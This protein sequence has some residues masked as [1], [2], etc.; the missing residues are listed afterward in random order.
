MKVA[1]FFSHNDFCPICKKYLTR[2]AEVDVMVD[3]AKPDDFILAGAVFYNFNGIR[4]TKNVD[5]LSHTKNHRTMMESICKKFPKTFTLNTRFTLRMNKSKL[6]D[7]IN[8]WFVN[9]FDARFIRMCNTVEHLY[10]YTSRYIIEGDAADAVEIDYEMINVHKFRIYNMFERH[11]PDRT[12]IADTTQEI[13]SQLPATMYNAL[14]SHITLPAI[15]LTK[16]N[17]ASYDS[18]RNQLEKYTILK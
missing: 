2:E 5:K 17:T 9:T 1:E 15:P 7:M 12:E 10:Y 13:K 6:S 14:S 8:P 18:I 11:V 3:R 4:F 16:W